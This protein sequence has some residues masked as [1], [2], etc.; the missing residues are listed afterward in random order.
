MKEIYIDP[1]GIATL[2]R[3]FEDIPQ[4]NILCGGWDGYQIYKID[5]R[6]YAVKE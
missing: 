6:L 5:D 2:V 1:I 3:K 4:P